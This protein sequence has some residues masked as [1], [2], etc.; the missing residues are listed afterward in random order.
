MGWQGRLGKARQARQAGKPGQAGRHGKQ[1][2]Q[3]KQGN[4]QMAQFDLEHSAVST[5]SED[6]NPEGGSKKGKPAQDVELS[7]VLQLH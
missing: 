4:L 2:R 1:G 3:G 6:S 7:S 5:E